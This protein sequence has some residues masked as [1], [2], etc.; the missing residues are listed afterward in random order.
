MTS[1]NPFQPNFCLIPWFCPYFPSCNSCNSGRGYSILRM[2][3]F[4]P[5]FCEMQYFFMLLSCVL[6]YNPQSLPGIT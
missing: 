4:L 2:V 6:D 3:K 1:R 5:E